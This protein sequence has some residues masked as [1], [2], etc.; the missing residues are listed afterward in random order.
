MATPKISS[1][2]PAEYTIPPE[3]FLIKLRKN[4][5]GVA[6][7]H[8][9]LDNN[10][11][12]LRRTLN[13]LQEE[14]DEITG[15]TLSDTT[16]ENLYVNKI[17]DDIIG[18]S[19]IKDGAIIASK[20]P[21]ASIVTAKIQSQQITT[22]LIKDGAI[23]TDKIA[24]GST[25][26]FSD[27]ISV[28]GVQVVDKDGNITGPVSLSAQQEIDLK[29]DPGDDFKYSDFTQSQLDALKGDPLTWNDLT[30]AQKLSLKGDTGASPTFRFENNTL[31]IT[32]V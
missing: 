32:N 6:L 15:G 8:D 17:A 30:D 26:D 7:S 31:T 20:I 12:V 2:S 5:D 28:G 29:G 4:L 23:T 1:D 9:A 27:G 22:D 10:W 18:S 3:Q 11:E 14:L 24:T 16:T 25:M 13:N 21:D 19:H